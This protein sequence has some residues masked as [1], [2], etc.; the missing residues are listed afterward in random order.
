MTVPT[1]SMVPSFAV[2]RNVPLTFG[3]VMT[4][5]PV[6]SSTNITVS[7]SSGVGRSNTKGAAPANTPTLDAATP[8]IPDPSP[9]N[10]PVK[11]SAEILPDT[12]RSR[13]PDIFLLPST[14]TAL[15]AVAIPA[16][17]L[18]RTFSSE[19]SMSVIPLSND[20]VPF[21]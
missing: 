2:V 7:N 4:W 19:S 5:S 21:A 16:C 11:V 10:D 15:F 1:A 17:T 20:R 8:V 18:S 12:V 6:G 14:T 3:M 13:I 9:L